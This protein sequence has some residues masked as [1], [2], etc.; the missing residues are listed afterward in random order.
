MSALRMDTAVTWTYEFSFTGQDP[1]KLYVLVYFSGTVRDPYA[2]ALV[3]AIPGITLVHIARQAQTAIL[4]VAIG[5]EAG[6]IEIV[7]QFPFVTS[8]GLVPVTGP[9]D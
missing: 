3:A 2:I 8:A 9:V 4:I 5:Q 7:K 1:T 6:W